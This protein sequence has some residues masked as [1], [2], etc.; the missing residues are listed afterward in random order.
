MQMFIF[1]PN[2]SFYTTGSATGEELVT[3]PVGQN[4]E[5]ASGAPIVAKQKPAC[6]SSWW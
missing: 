5:K 3:A 4:L 6:E 2:S 1:E